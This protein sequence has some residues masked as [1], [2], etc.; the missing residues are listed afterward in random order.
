MYRKYDTTYYKDK[1]TKIRNLFPDVNITT[2]VL[3]GFP[4]ETEEDFNSTYNFIKSIEF[5]EMHVFPYSRRPMTKAYNLPNQVD[6]VTKHYRVNKLLQLN[7]EL[8][9]KYRH[10]FLNKYVWVVVEEVRNG[11]ARGH[12]DNY[13]NVEVKANLNAN[14][15]VKVLITDVGYPICKGVLK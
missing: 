3:V 12:S 2:D 13:L 14:D 10:K 7:E 5:G 11:L 6:E 8:A 4:G 9:L 15:L 1:I